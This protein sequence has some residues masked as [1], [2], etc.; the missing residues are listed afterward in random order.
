MEVTAVAAFVIVSMFGS[1]S[2]LSLSVVLGQIQSVDKQSVVCTRV[3]GEVMEHAGDD[4]GTCI[5]SSL[6]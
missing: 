5:T 6:F 4:V 3:A 1:G 2:V